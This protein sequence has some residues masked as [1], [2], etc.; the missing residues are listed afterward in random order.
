MF[1]EQ[2]RGI[3]LDAL[4]TMIKVFTEQSLD[5]FIELISILTY[6]TLE[7]TEISLFGKA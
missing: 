3:Q 1:A 2:E 7:L 6:E 4:I 5:V